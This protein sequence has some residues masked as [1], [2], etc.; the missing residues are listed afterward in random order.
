MSRLALPPEIPAKL[1]RNTLY[2]VLC[3]G[4]S[5][6]VD[7]TVFEAGISDQAKEAQAR[8]LEDGVQ[9]SPNSKDVLRKTELAERKRKLA[10]ARTLNL[11]GA[12]G[13]SVQFSI[14][15]VLSRLRLAED[16]DVRAMHA[17][18][19]MTEENF[20][21]PSKP[22]PGR[23]ADARRLF[24]AQRLRL[25]MGAV[26]RHLAKGEWRTI[27][28][29][30][31]PEEFYF[32]RMAEAAPHLLWLLVLSS[33]PAYTPERL[34]KGIMGVEARCIM[35]NSRAFITRHESSAVW[36]ER[37]DTGVLT[38]AYAIRI[39]LEAAC[40]TCRDRH[41]RQGICAFDLVPEFEVPGVTIGDRVQVIRR[42]SMPDSHGRPMIHGAVKFITE[43]AH[44]ETVQLVMSPPPTFSPGRGTRI[45]GAVKYVVP[46][47]TLALTFF[48]P[49]FDKAA[50]AAAAAASRPRPMLAAAESSDSDSDS[51][52]EREAEAAAAARA[53]DFTE[54]ELERAR[55]LPRAGQA[56]AAA[57]QAAIGE[58]TAS[59]SGARAGGSKITA[60]GLARAM[61]VAQAQ[62]QAK[63]KGKGK[64][65]YIDLR[66][67]E[68]EAGAPAARRDLGEEMEA[69]APQPTE[70]ELE[71]ERA[72][73]EEAALAAAADAKA[74]RELEV[75]EE[76]AMELEREREREG[77]PDAEL[78]A[79][80]EAGAGDTFEPEP[81]V[82]E[83]YPLPPSPSL[84][85]APPPPIEEFSDDEPGD[86]GPRPPSS[87]PPPARP[88][89]S[90]LAALAAPA[91]L[92]PGYPLARP[93]PSPPRGTPVATPAS[94][95]GH[96]PLRPSGPRAGRLSRRAQQRRERERQLLRDQRAEAEADHDDGQASESD[97][98]PPR[99]TRLELARAELAAQPREAPEIDMSKYDDVTTYSKDN[100]SKKEAAIQ[101]ALR[102]FV[103]NN[104]IVRQRPYGPNSPPTF[105][106][107]LPNLFVY[108][109]VSANRHAGRGTM[110]EVIQLLAMTFHKTYESNP[111]PSTR[112]RLPEMPVIPGFAFACDTHFV[113]RAPQDSTGSACVL[114]MTHEE[115]RERYAGYMNTCYIQGRLPAGIEEATETCDWPTVYGM[116]HP[117]MPNVVKHLA[118]NGYVTADEFGY[119]AAVL[120][121]FNLVGPW[122]F[123]DK[124]VFDREPRAEMEPPSEGAML[125]YCG[126]IKGQSGTG[127]SMV[128]QIMTEC[129]P[130]SRVCVYR[131]SKG[132]AFSEHGGEEAICMVM[133]EGLDPR[134][135][136]E[137]ELKMRS[138]D[139]YSRNFKNVR[140]DDVRTKA[141]RKVLV[142]VCNSFP[143]LENRMLEF[144][145]RVVLIPLDH[146]PAK[147]RTYLH[148]D[149][150]E[151]E[152]PALM[153]AAFTFAWKI[154]HALSDGKASCIQ[155]FEPA[156]LR[157][158][159]LGFWQETTKCPLTRFIVT[160][161]AVDPT[162]YVAAPNTEGW[163][164][165]VAGIVEYIARTEGPDTSAAVGADIEN[166]R[167]DETLA[168]FGSS[169]RLYSYKLG[170]IWQTYIRGIVPKAP[171]SL[172]E[173][174][175]ALEAIAIPV[176][177]FKDP[178]ADVG[179][180]LVQP[181][182]KGK[183]KR[184][185]NSAPAFLPPQPPATAPQQRPGQ[186]RID[187]MLPRQ[188]TPTNGGA[189]PSGYGSSASS[190]SADGPSPV[191][192]PSAV[193]SAIQ[194]FGAQQEAERQAL[195]A[196]QAREAEERRQGLWAR[197]MQET[198][199]FRAELEAGFRAKRMSAAEAVESW[200]A[201][202]DGTVELAK[203]LGYSYRRAPVPT[204]YARRAAREASRAEI[205]AAEEQAAR[206]EAE[207]NARFRHLHH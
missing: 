169:C 105:Y 62:A 15:S 28:L 137:E 114:V 30:A 175:P 48:V 150:R 38:D 77:E 6:G 134:A 40:R 98:E 192:G 21:T 125:Q 64:A 139:A 33:D 129:L 89:P 145:A 63:G 94:S 31:G 184:T 65:A 144:F 206:E 188:G 124:P 140:G 47:R 81:P 74:S 37:P 53:L 112:G 80:V 68:E 70:E 113:V 58:A 116:L 203:G 71:A 149:I 8:A 133:A 190:A 12:P 151:N 104:R 18:L 73:E 66:F 173:S 132:S 43:F 167:L 193:L 69:A 115:A 174:Q 60:E 171:L 119:A 51:E 106:V 131:P 26:P 158:Q 161:C 165:S 22:K 44:T 93:I 84:D 164:T 177:Q 39:V 10:A 166:G 197:R 35:R 200:R 109:K 183:G 19:N 110:K 163:M 172:G 101:D 142:I 5:F 156:W 176:A 11:E 205:D 111:A 120:Y 23:D 78:A 185:R 25:L 83:F 170:G 130:P 199:A 136:S 52:A 191:P 178:V 76:Y 118:D 59:A 50:A 42:C 32:N 204:S 160:H 141:T 182:T 128:T 154:I 122:N 155:A 147:K 108:D 79:T 96:M 157:A 95:L 1:A 181:H 91:A 49:V 102:L 135:C 143:Q 162:T 34:A 117:F 17:A 72:M 67:E 107:E 13:P 92:R 29:L 7:W 45:C 121:A 194:G 100:K 202:E 90:A 20:D 189:G 168:G 54:E 87:P 97:G 127:K 86:A 3:V 16:A 85:G 55:S 180:F 152:L 126:I 82:D 14:D 123:C 148:S 2:D 138:G 187:E 24:A 103:K 41:G 195:A 196:R 198:A 36:G 99:A 153:V 46:R 207:D 88:L 179:P 201:F 146:K 56:M 186:Q 57:F 159:R 61:R 9:F 4:D 75:A 27:G